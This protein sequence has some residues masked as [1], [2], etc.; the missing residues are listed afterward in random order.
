MAVTC[1][2]LS[3]A[4]VMVDKDILLHVLNKVFGI[5]DTAL[6]WFESY[7]RP[8]NFRV[9]VSGKTSAEK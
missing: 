6:K 4:F 2:D 5:T 7:I 9:S 8:R 1:M 3:G